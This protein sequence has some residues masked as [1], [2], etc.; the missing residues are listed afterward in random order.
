MSQVGTDGAIV[1]PE[2]VRLDFDAANV[3]S[4]M[5]AI[6]IDLAIQGLAAFVLLLA[7]GLIASAGTGPGLPDWVALTLIL[8]LVF[9]LYFGYPIVFETFWRGRTPGKAAMG[10]RVVTVEGAPVTFRHA[11]IRAALG[12]IDF[13][14]S[15]GAAALISALVTRRHQRL[16]DLVAGTI[17]VRERSATPPP[18][19]VLF[20]I[21]PTLEPYAATIDVSGLGATDY[22]AVRQF[23]LRAGE[24]AP[25]VR[26]DLAAKL[27]G[28]LAQRLRH[29]PQGTVS[30]ELFLACVAVRY[31]RRVQQWS[32]QPTPAVMAP[33]PAV[34]PPPAPV[35]SPP[36]GFVP[37]A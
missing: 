4:R 1:T 37:P 9:V 5:V 33:P 26:L 30:P 16:G 19:P 8:V 7:F 18:V 21:P 10:L 24:L 25:H 17:V 31:Q 28:P 12:L 34:P 20:R 35:E 13:Y 2:A 15:S 11:A 29:V 14:A 36:G 6:G 23:L 32:P 3:G 27:A 22:A